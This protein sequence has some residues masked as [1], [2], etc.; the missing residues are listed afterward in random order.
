MA[1][2][3]KNEAAREQAFTLRP[4]HILVKSENGAAEADSSESDLMMDETMSCS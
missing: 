1:T 2:T 3:S 4:G